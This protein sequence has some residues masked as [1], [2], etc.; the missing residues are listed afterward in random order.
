MKDTTPYTK[1]Q[2]ACQPDCSV[3]AGKNISIR[4]FDVSAIKFIIKFKVNLSADPFLLDPMLQT[5]ATSANP[6]ISTTSAGCIPAGQIT[7]Y[8]TLVLSS[9][10]CM[11]AFSILISKDVARL[12]CWDHAGAIITTPIYYDRDPQL[13]DFLIHYNNASPQIRGYDTTIIKANVDEEQC[14]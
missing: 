5:K 12:I 14:A 4:E 7:A 1:F 13:Y 11:H 8:A 10:Y 3:F 6:L 9:Q 2:F